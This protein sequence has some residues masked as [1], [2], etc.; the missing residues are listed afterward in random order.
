M[1]ALH[2][3]TRLRTSDVVQGW[4]SI[5]ML[6]ARASLNPTVLTVTLNWMRGATRKP[7]RGSLM[8]I[9]AAKERTKR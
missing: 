7:T 1:Q 6:R 9:Q 5:V 2:T 8:R 4:S 3:L